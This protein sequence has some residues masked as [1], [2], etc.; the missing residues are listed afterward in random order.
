ML[1]ISTK[2]NR[3]SNKAQIWYADFVI[4]LFLFI[5]TILLYF[6]YTNNLQ[7]QEEGSIE[8][9]LTDV[10][11]ISSSLVMGGYPDNWNNATVLRIGIADEQK[12]NP[13]KLR[14]FKKL[15][16]TKSRTLFS[17][18]FDYFVFFVNS[19]GEVLNIN[20]VCGVGSPNINVT[21]SF[22]SA[23]YYSGAGDMVLRDF[24][25]NSIK[26]DI[27]FGDDGNNVDDIDGLI[28]N[29]SKYALV[30]L[31]HPSLVGSNY[32]GF[33][34][35]MEAYSANGGNS[36]ISG[37]LITSNDRN[38]L[39]IDFKKKAGQS[40]SDKQ[41][42]VNNTDEFLSFSK[43]DNMTFSQAY[44]ILNTSSS[45]NFKLISSFVKDNNYA[46]GKWE[47]GK[48]TNYFFSDFNV[49]FF[50]GNFAEVMQDLASGFIQ[51]TCSDVNTAS[52]NAKKLVKTERYLNYNS[53]IVKMVIYLWR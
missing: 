18:G 31:E 23:Y 34:T 36:I 5:L 17:T 2:L 48:G 14:N 25:A 38:M 24:M 46:G 7:T 12:L 50:N 52:I 28:S 1:Y 10:K 29:L 43:G 35:A 37:Q 15:N 39:G 41:A 30:V 11:G 8:V 9:M 27:Y 4:A 33:K 26:S 32:N 40:V 21:S 47:F 51:G 20:G 42:T 22:R 53:Q 16:Y 19:R 6:N 45:A 44:Y 49:D 13:D 3:L